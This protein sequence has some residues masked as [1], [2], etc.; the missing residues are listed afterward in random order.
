MVNVFGDSIARVSGNLQVVEK[1][2]GRVGKFKDYI[3]E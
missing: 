1:V 3:D 2:V